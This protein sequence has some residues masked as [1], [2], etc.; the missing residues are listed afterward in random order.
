MILFAWKMWLMGCIKLGQ[1][2]SDVE[3]CRT[4]LS[5]QHTSGCQ[6]GDH[7]FCENHSTKKFPTTHWCG[8]LQVT[9]VTPSSMNISLATNKH[10]TVTGPNHIFFCH[11]VATDEQVWLLTFD[12]FSTCS[13]LKAIACFWGVSTTSSSASGLP[14]FSVKWNESVQCFTVLYKLPL[15]KD[16]AAVPTSS[17]MR[18]IHLFTITH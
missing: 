10:S 15:L 6:T 11:T 5:Q 1:V 8:F 7:V 12:L 16:R 13:P 2:W 14:L 4:W 9:I 18:T 17:V 3:T